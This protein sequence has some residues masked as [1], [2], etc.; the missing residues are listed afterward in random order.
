[1]EAP[2]LKCTSFGM[3]VYI[4]CEIEAYQIEILGKPFLL[5]YILSLFQE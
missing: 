3:L 2:V 1:M 4:I 5:F